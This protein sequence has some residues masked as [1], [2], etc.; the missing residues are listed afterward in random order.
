M[1]KQEYNLSSSSPIPSKLLLGPDKLSIPT[2]EQKKNT[3][4]QMTENSVTNSGQA[5]TIF[6]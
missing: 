1:F 4:Q 2:L 6:I 5:R 3:M